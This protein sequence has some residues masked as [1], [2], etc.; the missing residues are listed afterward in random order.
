[1]TNNEMYNVQKTNN[2]INNEKYNI[3]KPFIKQITKGII[4]RK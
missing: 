2:K 3:Q 4:Y 1:M